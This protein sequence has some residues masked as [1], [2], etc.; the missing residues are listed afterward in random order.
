M[1]TWIWIGSGVVFVLIVGTVVLFLRTVQERQRHI[2]V[3]NDSTF[4]SGP[5]DVGGYVDY[6]AAVNE[7]FSVGVTRENN[8]A[9]VLV[10]ATGIKGV[11]P[12]HQAA[13]LSALG[14]K[15]EEVGEGVVVKLSDVIGRDEE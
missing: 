6:V 15:K 4:V 10:Q 8:A 3:G 14:L 9:V 1:R 11:T 12:P 13:F 7:E 5:V 2:R